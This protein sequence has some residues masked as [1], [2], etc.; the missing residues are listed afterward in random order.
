MSQFLCDGF[1]GAPVYFPAQGLLVTVCRCLG[2]AADLAAEGAR[3][4]ASLLKRFWCYC[5]AWQELDPLY[6]SESELNEELFGDVF[7]PGGALPV[8]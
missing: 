6:L 3:E 8:F 7:F 4:T 2:A 5:L 1:T